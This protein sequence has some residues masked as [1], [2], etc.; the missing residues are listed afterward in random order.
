MKIMSIKLKGYEYKATIESSKYGMIAEIH[1]SKIC[2]LYWIRFLKEIDDKLD[3]VAVKV[4]NGTSTGIKA[5]KKLIQEKL[6]A[7]VAYK[8]KNLEVIEKIKFKFNKRAEVKKI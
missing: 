8:P 1:K 7:E 2:S 4:R 3:L 6:F 5:I